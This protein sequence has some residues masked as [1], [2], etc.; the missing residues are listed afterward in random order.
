M[1]ALDQSAA[2]HSL[3]VVHH[4]R[5]ARRD[6]RHRLVERELDL[7]VVEPND[8]GARRR[9][10]DAEPEPR[11]ARRPSAR[12]TS[13]FTS[14]ATTPRPSSSSRGPIT[15]ARSPG[16]IATT[17]IGSRNPPGSP[18]RWPIVKRAN[19][20]CSPTTVPSDEYEWPARQR[21]RVG[22]EPLAND[23]R[24]VAVGDEA[25]V[26]A[27]HLLGDRPR[28]RACARRRASRPWSARRRAAACATAPSGRF[29]RG[30][31]TGPSP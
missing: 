28:V 14:R 18:R 11:R 26:L 21:R 15:T 30:N 8:F 31:T 9:A 2:E 4:E 3:A 12:S 24:V 29:P 27:L 7:V 20:S 10:R 25:D 16:R 13:Q 19:P 22:A 1:S 5:L 6:R 23:L 17:N